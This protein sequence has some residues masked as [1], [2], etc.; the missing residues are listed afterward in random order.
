MA[1]GLF[2]LRRDDITGWWV[3]VVVDREFDRSRFA[4]PA[5]PVPGGD[6]RCQNCALPAAPGQVWVRALKPQAFTVAGGERDAREEG[7]DERDPELGLLG[8]IGSWQTIVAPKGH[9]GTLA[10]ESEAVVLQMLTHARDQIGVARA[11]SGTQYLQVVQNWGAQAGARTNHLCLDFYDLPLIPHRIGEE[12]GGAARYVIREGTCPFC[13]LV[14]DEVAGRQRLVFED[15]ASVCFAPYASRSPF[16]LWVVPRHHEADFGRATDAQLTS[17][18]ETLR[19]VLR[20][21]DALDGPAYNLVLHTAPLHERVDDTYHWHWEIHP[22]LRAIAGLELGTGLPV[23]PVSPEDAVEELL[24]AASAGNRA[25]ATAAGSRDAEADAAT[26]DARVAH[27]A[28][29]A[30]A[31]GVASA[32]AGRSWDEFP[33]EGVR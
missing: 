13:R 30:A 19:K 7:R 26:S 9:H 17:A 23:N 32:P 2:E 28:G 27:G 4:L 22:R 20:L 8:D 10:D 11:G 15:A 14:R 25:R 5:R 16:E 33:R 21:L 3:A 1:G 18:A 31:A 29:A 6:D 24:A 12:L